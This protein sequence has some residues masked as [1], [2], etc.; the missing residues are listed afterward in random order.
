MKFFDAHTHVHFAAYQEDWRQVIDRALEAGVQ[1]M[2]VGTQKDTSA[3]AVEMAALYPEGVYAAVGMHPV[4]TDKSYHD[5]KELGGSDEAREF[6]THGEV[7]DFAYYKKL[8]QDPKVLA[9]GECGLDYYRMKDDSDGSKKEKQREAFIQHIS[10]AQEVKKPLMIHCRQASGDALDILRAH[11]DMLLSDNPG[12]FHF[13]TDS[14]EDAKGFLDLGFS[15]SIGGVVTF[16]RDYDEMVHM[17][18]LERILSET[19]AP[20]V[21]PV[22]YRGKRNEPA[23]VVE[24]VKR[25]GEIRSMPFEEITEAIWKNSA[26]VLSFPL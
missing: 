15:F 24:T 19:D 14:K 22:P 20:Y 7:F 11:K 1:M 26:R 4:H 6:A 23:Y 25:I 13:Y 5:E 9:I 3:K 18:P 21:A 10:L 8:A 16:T 2:N 17:Y 12:I